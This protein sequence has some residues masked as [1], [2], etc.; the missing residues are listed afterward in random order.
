[1]G[2]RSIAPAAI[3]GTGMNGGDD[4]SLYGMILC[5]A[6]HAPTSDPLR[7]HSN[8]YKYDHK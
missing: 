7:R 5:A 1:M 4:N 8:P 6:I 3:I 2:N